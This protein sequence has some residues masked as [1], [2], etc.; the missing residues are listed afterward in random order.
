MKIDRVRKVHVREAV[1]FEKAMTK[2]GRKQKN[3]RKTG[4]NGRRQIIVK[5]M[6]IEEL[7]KGKS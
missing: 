4:A 3:G 5:K 1:R 6:Y 7:P 2:V